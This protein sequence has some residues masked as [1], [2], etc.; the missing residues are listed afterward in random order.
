MTLTPMMAGVLVTS[1]ASGR[2]ISRIG[3]YRPFPIAGTAMM[4]VGLGLLATLGV[5]TSIWTACALHARAR[6]RARPGHAGAGAGG[7]ERGRLSR[8][9]RRH[10]G[11]DAVPLDRRLGRRLAVRRDLHRDADARTSPAALPAGTAP[12][13][14]DRAGRHPGAAGGDADGL[15]R[16]PSPPR[17]TR[18]SATPRR[19]PRWLSRS[20][21]FS[22]SCRCAV[23]RAGSPKPNSHDQDDRWLPDALRRRP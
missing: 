12:A 18:F 10:L 3:R 8:S 19:W 16:T 15:S 23:R 7:A 14:R 5:G 11:R 21:G 6:A 13:R 2:I 9:R 20:P 22:R 1:I 4:T 17:S